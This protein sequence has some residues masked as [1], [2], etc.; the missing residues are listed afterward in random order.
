ME[1]LYEKQLNYNQISFRYSRGKSH[2]N[3]NEIHPYHEILYYMDGD[4]TFLSEEFQE[5]LSSG[6]LLLIPK[7]SYH[8]FNIGNQSKYTRLV[9]NFPDMDGTEGLLASTMSEI[10]IIRNLNSHLSGILKRMCQVLSSERPVEERSIFLQGAFLMLLAELNLEE[11]EISSPRPRQG[12]QLISR[13]IQYIDKK[14]TSDIGA[15]VIAREMNVSVST[16][17]HSFKKELGI[18]VHRYIIE[19]RLIYAHKLISEG[20]KPTKIYLECGY[21]DYPTFYKAYLKMFGHTPSADHLV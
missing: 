19:K 6:T 18:S 12:D 13:C 14:F 21:N 2:I 7:A 5:E 8:Q 3:G 16:L 10:R 17:F 20:G 15:E 9:L 1:N 4:V 11:V